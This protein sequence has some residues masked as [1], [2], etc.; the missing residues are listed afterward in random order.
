MK[1]TFYFIATLTISLL[2]FNGCQKEQ[3]ADRPVIDNNQSKTTIWVSSDEILSAMDKSLLE[4][5]IINVGVP[6]NLLKSANVVNQDYFPIIKVI[7]SMKQT[8]LKLAIRNEYEV[9]GNKGYHQM[10]MIALGLPAHIQ[11][12]NIERIRFARKE[13]DGELNFDNLL[14]YDMKIPELKPIKAINTESKVLKID[15]GTEN[16]ECLY[17]EIIFNQSYKSSD[18]P[19]YYKSADHWYS[20]DMNGIGK[21]DPNFP[22]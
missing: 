22:N 19:Y 20:R 4:G 14:W 5:A 1:K 16:N 21:L 8:V 15:K 7:Q 10:S 11:K 13:I 12:E 3:F 6:N 17:I 18:M 2:I 9:N